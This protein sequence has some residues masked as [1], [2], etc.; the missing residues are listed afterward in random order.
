[1]LFVAVQVTKEPSGFN[2]SGLRLDFSCQS[3]PGPCVCP[4]AALL[5]ATVKRPAVVGRLRGG[6]A[7]HGAA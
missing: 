1:M 6:P 2:L 5:G 4:P 3:K 7:D